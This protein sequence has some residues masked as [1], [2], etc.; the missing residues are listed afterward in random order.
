MIAL[1]SGLY[2]GDNG[3]E[4]NSFVHAQRFARRKDAKAE[5]AKLLG[6]PKARII[7]VDVS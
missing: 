2:L 5:F 1:E 7:K 6:W 3:Y 4:T